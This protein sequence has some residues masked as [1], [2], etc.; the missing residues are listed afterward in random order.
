MLIYSKLIEEVKKV[1]NTRTRKDKMTVTT[2]L[3]MRRRLE[4]DKTV[5]SDY[6]IMYSAVVM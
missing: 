3:L 1:S 2:L 5:L 6:D 4:D